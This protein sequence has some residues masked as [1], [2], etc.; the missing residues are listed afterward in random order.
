LENDLRLKNHS[1]LFCTTEQ[2][3]LGL[4]E[5]LTRVLAFL[6]FCFMPV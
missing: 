3:D 1:H 6:K 4:S 5:G 2:N